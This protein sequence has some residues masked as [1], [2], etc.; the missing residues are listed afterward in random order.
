MPRAGI[1]NLAAFKRWIRKV[2]RQDIPDRGS[3]LLKRIAFE[4]FTRIIQRTPVDTGR[5]RGNWQASVNAP[6]NNIVERDD[7]AGFVTL[8]DGLDSLSDIKAGTVV[9]I[10]NNLP[11]AERIENG[12][13]ANNVPGQMVGRT[14]KELSK[15][16]FG[17]L[18]GGTIT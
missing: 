17:G 4:A 2:S 12:H 18:G 13:G 14:L 11:Y 10:T 9:W 6:K 15:L 3:L 1:S 16:D 8:A 7:K 5:L